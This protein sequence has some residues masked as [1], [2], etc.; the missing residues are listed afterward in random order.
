MAKHRTMGSGIENNNNDKMMMM[1][2]EEE[3]SYELCHLFIIE[4]HQ[5]L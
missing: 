2:E 1:R 3:L 4:R 5:N